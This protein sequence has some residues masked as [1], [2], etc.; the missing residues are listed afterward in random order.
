MMDETHD[1]RRRSWVA[2]ANVP[3]HDFPLQNLPVG[4]FSRAGGEPRP[5]V[6]IGDE[7]LDL[8]HCVDAGVIAD[9]QLAA[10]LRAC[11]QGL[12]P[13]MAAGKPV[14][15]KLRKTVFQL[16]DEQ[17]PAASPAGGDWR[18]QALVPAAQARMH[19]PCR[20][21]DYTD[22][23]TSVWHTERHGR[24][25]GLAD[26]LPRAFK[27]LPVAY[28]GRASSIRASGYDV[29]RPHGQWLDAGSGEVRFGPAQALDFE[30]EFAAFIGQGNALGE[31]LR[32]DAAVRHVFGYCLLND[33][34]SKQVQWWEQVLGP[35][36]GKSFGTTISPWIVM[37]EALE[38][39][40]QPAPARQ[41]GDPAPQAYLASPHHDRHGG[42][43]VSLQA[44]LRTEA[45]RAAG[46]PPQAI[47]RTA[48]SNL[49]W[50][51][52]Q[53]VTH[54]ASNGCN[55]QPGDLLGTGTVS[56]QDELSMA[57]MTEK[58]QAGRVPFPLSNG[59]ERLWLADGDEIILT[60]RAEKEGFVPIGFGECRAR[61][62]PAGEWPGT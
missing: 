1:P 13:L 32:L 44:A 38:P 21:G 56:G 22:F 16:L 3:G 40:R 57:C 43:A 41:A 10:A 9:P 49:Y 18:S 25:K 14:S 20:I 50:T 36:L 35:F 60:A 31:P 28:H 27:H 15:G 29:R 30:T 23:L 19:L 52:P 62:L 24:F 46:L 39:F 47:V 8:L 12:N 59:E 55:L 61:L 37:D 17:A 11:T 48:L 54:H 26:P 45:M 34:S 4:M 5:G 2:S 53:M 6:A 51:V 42:L 7:I 33:W 58:T